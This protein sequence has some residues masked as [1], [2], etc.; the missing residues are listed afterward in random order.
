MNETASPILEM[1]ITLQNL[2][3]GKLARGRL[4]KTGLYKIAIRF[5][6]VFVIFYG[7]RKSF[8]YASKFSESVNSPKLRFF[9]SESR[10]S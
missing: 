10:T 6:D 2:F 3:L 9:P 1:R 5:F 4:K 8:S 7:Q